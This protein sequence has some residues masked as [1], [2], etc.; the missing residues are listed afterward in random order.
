MMKKPQSILKTERG[1]VV[2]LEILVVSTLA[3]VLLLVS[4]KMWQ[5]GQAKL[6]G[7]P[8]TAAPQMT[9]LKK[10]EPVQKYL[11][12]VEW[13]VRLPYAGDDFSYTLTSA[14]SVIIHS[15]ALKDKDPACASAG[16]GISR[17]KPTDK[18]YADG[19]GP[20]V[21]DYAKQIPGLYTQVGRYYYTFVA[22][23]AV[24]VTENRAAQDLQ[25]ETNHIIK[26]LVPKLQLVK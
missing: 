4:Y 1:F 2:L 11:T 18:A 9:G 10:A 21:E 15:K 6:T 14:S 24:C 3:A 7:N 17:F 16:G 26:N 19:T 12:I 25:A 22:D 5:N 8:G 20:A 23:K 13:G